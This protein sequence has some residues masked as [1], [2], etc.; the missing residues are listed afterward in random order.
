M[1][2]YLLVFGAL[3]VFTLVTVGASYLDVS[4]PMA[5]LI[6]LLIASVKAS[7]VACYFMHLISERKA[8]YSVLLLCVFFLIALMLL[9]ILTQAEAEA[10]QHVT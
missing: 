10:L 4:V 8:L 3:A 6:A 9:P 1:R 5:I 7:L 2:V